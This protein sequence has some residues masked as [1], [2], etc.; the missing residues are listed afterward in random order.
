MKGRDAAGLK[1]VLEA[2]AVNPLEYLSRIAAVQAGR[3]FAETLN[4]KFASVMPVFEELLQAE[5]KS[6][7]EEGYLNFEKAFFEYVEGSKDQD[8][9]NFSRKHL[10]V[11][12]RKSPG[13]P[14]LIERAMNVLNDAGFEFSMELAKRINKRRATMFHSSIVMSDKDVT[15]FYEETSAVTAMLMLLTLRN[16]GVD[17]KMLPSHHSF[18]SNFR[19]FAKKPS[20]PEEGA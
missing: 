16:L 4:E 7:D 20:A 10:R 8:L 13:L 17:L 19:Q 6:G 18:T 5:F 14:T 1:E 2:Y 11:V 15:A 12:D 9:V 3:W